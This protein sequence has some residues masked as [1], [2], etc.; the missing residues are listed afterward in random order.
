VFSTIEAVLFLG[1]QFTTVH[2]ISGLLVIGGL[3]IA[4]ITTKAFKAS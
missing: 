1:E 3:V 4:N 2:L